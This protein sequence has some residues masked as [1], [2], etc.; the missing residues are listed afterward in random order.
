MNVGKPPDFDKLFAH[1]G[2]FAMAYAKLTAYAI[3]VINKRKG[4]S[5]NGR[6]IEKLDAQELVKHALSRLVE[7]EDINDG[8]AVYCLL[9]RHI[10][11]YVRT[12]QKQK[13]NPTLVQIATSGYEEG[14]AR[15]SEPKVE[16]TKNPAE[17]SEQKDENEFYKELLAQT[18]L[19]FKSEGV[20]FALLELVIEGW[21]DRSELAAL[22]E[23][24]PQ[25]YDVILKRV[26]RAAISLKD[27]LLRN[28][29]K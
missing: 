9:R 10:D 12:I 13:T 21:S 26:S 28:V 18:K 2:G 6:I 1:R 25:Q 22:L 23:I 8:E 4:P 16:N 17:T 29:K 20:E 19:K 14:S 15:I 3:T 5:K 27:Q 7:C 11:N 24:T